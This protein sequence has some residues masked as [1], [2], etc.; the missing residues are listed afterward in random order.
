MTIPE[1][2]TALKD[3]DFDELTEDNF[4]YN[5]ID[6]I[7]CDVD[8]GNGVTKVAIFFPDTD[9]VVKI[10][11]SGYEEPEEEYDEETDEYYETGEYDYS[12]FQFADDNQTGDDYCRVELLIY[13][14]AKSENL[15]FLFAPTSFIGYVKD[16][17]IYIQPICEPYSKR[18]PKDQKKESVDS[19]KKT[20][21]EKNYY[22]FN[23]NW[24]ADVLECYGEEIFNKFCQFI[25]DEK[26]NDL[27]SDNIGYCRGKPVLFDYSGFND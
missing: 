6:N 24:L 13:E 19:A 4:E 17:P 11:F 3:C 5:V 1:I 27:H 23:A 21:K 9:F 14:E 15:D 7:P 2:L 20:C 16:H 10:P 12:S 26:I 22:C 18:Y 8:Y 25:Q